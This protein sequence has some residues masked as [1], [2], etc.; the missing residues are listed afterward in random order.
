M[1]CGKKG[2]VLPPCTSSSAYESGGGGPPP[3]RPPDHAVAVSLGG[4]AA[5][6]LGEPFAWG[7]G[8]R[9]PDAEETAAEHADF[10]P[11]SAQEHEMETVGSAST[12]ALSLFILHRR[13]VMC[14]FV[15][16]RQKRARVY[17]DPWMDPS[18]PLGDRYPTQGCK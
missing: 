14:M 15:C 5:E 4:L 9:D 12:K 8:R 2:R 1:W 17:M 18:R 7:S 16:S 11:R 3:P 10:N 6:E 13:C